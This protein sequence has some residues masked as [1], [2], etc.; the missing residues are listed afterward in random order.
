MLTIL[1]DFSRAVWVYFMIDKTQVA[2]M[3]TAFFAYIKNHFAHTIK[4][5]RSDNGG[6]FLNHTCSTLFSSLGVIHQQ[7]C[8]HTPQQ[9][10]RVERK[11]RHLVQIARALLFNSGLPIS[12]WGEALLTASFLIN[13]LPTK[14]LNWKC[15]Y[16]VLTG[17]VS[18]YD[19]LRVFGCLCYV[20]NTNPHKKKFDI[21][22]QKGIFVGFASSKKHINF[23]C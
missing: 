12:F 21:W 22:A 7:S 20:T 9:N 18:T 16:K 8:P 17:K 5:I 19:S 3:L 11:H 15:P 10:G 23:F 13:K 4:T 1:D 6:E 14:I 2:S